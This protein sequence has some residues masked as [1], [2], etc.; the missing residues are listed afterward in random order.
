MSE[1]FFKIRIEM[2][3]KVQAFLLLSTLFNETKNIQKKIDFI[4]IF[5]FLRNAAFFFNASH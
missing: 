2:E 1:D 4:F 5:S 3:L